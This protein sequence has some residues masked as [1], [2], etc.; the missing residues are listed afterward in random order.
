M[1][2]I[3]KP[4]P[5]VLSGNVADNWRRFKQR[6][7]IYLTLSGFAEQNN[8]VKTYA[9]LN[10]VGDEGLDVYN[11]FTFQSEADKLKYKDV[12]EK[13]EAYCVP[14]TNVIMER[15]HFNK[16][17][18][19]ATETADQ[20]I[21][22]L[23]A[24]SQTC[25]FGDLRESLIR[26][27]MVVG[28]RD[29][30]ARE[31][32]LRE[33]DLTLKKAT[34][35]VRASEM[36][37]L[38]M[39]ELRPE[40]STAAAHDVHAVKKALKKG[41]KTVK[42]KHR[43]AEEQE[44]G[45]QTANQEKKKK[46]YRCKRC[47]NKHEYM[48]C[49]AWG[50]ECTRCGGH[51]HFA[52]CCRSKSVHT[53]EQQTSDDS[54][55]N[56]P[57]AEV[58]LGSIEAE[59]TCINGIELE[60]KEDWIVPLDINGSLIPVKVDSGA[61]ANV[62]SHKDYKSLAQQPK[63]HQSA[64]HLKAYNGQAMETLGVCRTQV[65]VQGKKYN[66][67]FVIVPERDRQP[68]LSNVTSERLGLIKKA[69][70][71]RRVHAVENN[72]PGD[73]KEEVERKY[74]SLF[75]GQGCLPGVHRFVLKQDVEPVIHAPRR[76]PN[77]L[78]EKL[79][80]ELERQ[81]KLGYI[82]KQ[83]E[84]TDWVNSIVIVEKASGDIRICIDPKDLNKAL[85]REHYQLPTKEE[86]LCDM[87]GAK[88]F[89][90][91]DAASGFHQ[92]KLDEESSLMTTFNTPFGRYRYLRLPMG[93][94]S[95]P[96]V[97]HKTMVQYLQELD[98]VR[99]F[100]D[101]IIIWGSSQEE[102]DIRVHVVLSKLSQIGLKL[103][104]T[105][106]Y[107]RMK[108]ITYLGDVISEKGVQPDPQKVQ[109]ILDLRK[110][111]SI[112]DLQRA[113]G[114]VNY[115]ARFIPNVSAKTRALRSLTQKDVIWQWGHEHEQEWNCIKE[116][117]SSYPVL[118]HFDSNKPLKISSDASKEGLGAVLMQETEKEWMP[119]AYAS[120]AMTKAEQNYAQI[121]KEL[122]GIV[123]ACEKFH[124]YIYGRKFLGETDHKPLI[125][126]WKKPLSQATPRLQRLLLRLQKY[127]F[128][129]E[130]VPGKYL[131]TADTLSRAFT[132]KNS[133]S[134]TENA[135]EV[136][137]CSF[138]RGRPLTDEKWELIAEETQKDPVLKSVMSAICHGSECPN[139]Y[140]K[141][142]EDLTILDGVLLKGQKIIIPSTMRGEMLHTIHEGHLGIEKCK[143]RARQSMYWPN[144]NEEI[145]EFIGKC[146]TCQIQRYAQQKEP[147]QPHERP[148]RPWAKVGCDLFY[149]K[150]QA[151]LIVVDYFSHYP[152]IAHLTAEGTSQ[153]TRKLRS[154]FARHG[155]PSEVVS[156]GGP[157]FGSQEFLE[158]SQAWGFSHII[159]SPYFPQSN[160]LVEN[161]V[162]I[163]K[164][165]LTKAEKSNQD[166]YLALLAYRDAPLECGK[167][168]AQLLMGRRLQTRLPSK[169]FKQDN[170]ASPATAVK[171][172][173]ALEPLG[174][175]QI[176]RVRG[177]GQWPKRGVILGQTGPR[178]YD[179]QTEDGAI[180]NRNRQ[181]LL[182]T[183]ENCRLQ[184]T[185]TPTEEVLTN[186]DIL[187]QQVV[188]QSTAVK[189]FTPCEQQATEPVN[190]PV[191]RHY[192][193]RERKAPER[194]DL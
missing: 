115:L 97:F 106:C 148:D 94:S 160:G 32:L 111:C 132:D 144:M 21:T 62:M 173:K 5:L 57:D 55:S 6:F 116:I 93:V 16:C 69:K 46:K 129:L 60:K 59:T 119:V 102:H 175:G 82:T 51:N 161:A 185:S 189:A 77:T 171:R 71:V 165:L 11:T 123:Y 154:I 27:R 141:S 66:V 167:S 90:K 103:N 76:V 86:I 138:K 41:S 20:Y 99:V 30:K 13:F 37:K 172:G 179:V 136:H 26:D 108:E 98:G 29:D 88:F 73:F 193:G 181:H 158:F 186:V 146:E 56:D 113:L 164:R 163:I 104:S 34:D 169:L 64:V 91:L 101:D 147:M 170:W 121:E 45:K 7:E 14:K 47:G 25:E 166:P 157:Q 52:S 17:T 180:Y 18:Q 127:D 137:V 117:L 174:E 187:P 65:S 50:K 19:N 177:N 153:V 85:K 126:I 110:P 194:L 112:E 80:K 68:V 40:T 42:D 130:Y 39:D 70:V 168:P 53:V 81:V 28:I 122:L 150:K 24:L 190:P 120:R 143:R 128:D 10:A 182:A 151:Y 9:L 125:T 134:S 74:P 156:D 83:E 95:A 87:A 75:S 92:I 31:R 58:F 96:E 2:H 33:P 152:E 149:I 140:R 43:D 12:M 22:R 54:E 142:I 48:K 145:A 139:P 159:T 191:E 78:R 155:I 89:T 63:L 15:F 176:V 72:I 1:E 178:S 114:M 4:K 100:M 135:V 162:K 188:K 8:S 192:P 184:Q 3:E 118:Q 49:P 67:V 35:I 107:Y 84:P 61:Q 105:K 36:A 38:Q 131:V 44:D 79:K 133:H 109:G 183:K 23:K 124:N